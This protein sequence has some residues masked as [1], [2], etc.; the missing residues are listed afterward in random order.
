MNG[1]NFTEGTRRVL[2]EARKEAVRLTHEYVGTEHILIALLRDPNEAPAMAVSRIGAQPGDVI[3]A[4]EVAS[5]GNAPR[6]SNDLPYTS[7]AKKVIELAMKEAR[8]LNHDHVDTLHL[9]VGVLAEER[10]IGAQ[11]LTNHGIS[12]VAAREELTRVTPELNTISPLPTKGVLGMLTRWW[13]GCGVTHVTVT[14]V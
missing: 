9:L 2:A 4:V 3:H 13:W 11:V 8:L 7:R 5:A 10:G 6:T 1:Y 14:V 12:L